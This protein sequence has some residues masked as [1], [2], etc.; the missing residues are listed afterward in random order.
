MN[1]SR[2]IWSI[3][4]STIYATGLSTLWCPSDGDVSR[5]VNIGLPLSSDWGSATATV[6]YTDYTA[7]FGTWLSEPY[8]YA[9]TTTF[10]PGINS[11]PN[12]QAMQANGNG[13][14]NLN[15][16]YNISAVTDG[17]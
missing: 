6:R 1:F 13:I 3:A 8:N 4:N 9:K 11:N 10:S 17:T 12:L 2:N 7:C 15:S 16:S 14:F 5:A